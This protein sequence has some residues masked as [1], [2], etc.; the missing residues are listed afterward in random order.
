MKLTKTDFIHY[1][2][3]PESLWLLKNRPEEYPK[4]E[5]SLF[6][7]KLIKDGY[8]VEEFAQQLFPEAIQ[9]HSFGTTHDTQV[10]LYQKRKFFLQA[11]FETK[12]GVFSRIDVLERLSNNKW[13]IYE[14]KSSNEVSTKKKHN[15]ILDACFQKFVLQE[16]GLEVS[17]VSIIH[18]NRD[19][20]KY[21]TIN[22]NDLL[23]I[24]DIT[25]MVNNEYSGVVNQIN[26]A[27]TLINKSV[28]DTPTCSC[29][30]KTRN[31]HCDSFTGLKN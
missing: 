1:L 7:K 22:V 17:K 28:I 9:L 25:E 3:C 21:N 19:Y 15:H 5:F 16:N 24:A 6:I 12:N 26:A 18:L 23:V 20:I 30:R 14:V 31:N 4:G 27:S 29:L 11:T 2:K 8:E 10:A 13:H